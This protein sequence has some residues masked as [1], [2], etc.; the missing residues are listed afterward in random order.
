MNKDIPK[1]MDE[2]LYNLLG[3]DLQ[4]RIKGLERE[5]WQAV[6]GV[7]VS[8]RWKLEG[9]LGIDTLPKKYTLIDNSNIVES[10]VLLYYNLRKKARTFEVTVVVAGESYGYDDLFVGDVVTK[11]ARVGK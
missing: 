11:L 7:Y 9:T 3:S 2:S 6:F 5:L 1:L 10:L 8:K 4:A